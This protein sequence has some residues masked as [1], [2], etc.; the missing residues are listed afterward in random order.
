MSLESAILTEVAHRHISFEVARMYAPD[1]ALTPDER[2]RMAL[3]EWLF[4]LGSGNQ[5]VNP[6]H[7]ERN[8]TMSEAFE[9][10]QWMKRC[11]YAR[12]QPRG[13]G[14][15]YAE[16]T[17]EGRSYIVQLRGDR[18]N[19]LERDRAVQKAI[20]R[21][22]YDLGATSARSPMTPNISAFVS[23]SS[24]EFLGEPVTL[25][26]GSKNAI[27][28]FEKEFISGISSWGT[29]PP[30]RMHLTAK[31]LDCID[32]ADGDP[33]LFGSFSAG[34]SFHVTGGVVQYAGA[35]SMQ[36]IG[37]IGHVGEAVNDLSVA[38]EGLNLLCKLADAYG[39][40]SIEDL[41]REKEEA[42]HDL[43]GAA[44]D[45]SRARAF[46]ERVKS[47]AE[48]GGQA[49][50][51]AAISAASSDTVNALMQAQPHQGH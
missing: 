43:Q 23:S 32:R 29:A 10:L 1:M 18:D 27:V 17:A 16:L 47:L 41:Q 19:V 44:P 34:P 8:S 40:G 12:V 28:L 46:C 20:L 11:G 51:F 39:L 31:G 24:A 48:R 3:V 9:D 15:N 45:S 50:V 21:W 30:S 2:R 13:G 25:E 49:A 22:L 38:I 33:R 14:E 5:W 6:F 7:K 36:T 26:V 37:D 42:T 35:N 4:D